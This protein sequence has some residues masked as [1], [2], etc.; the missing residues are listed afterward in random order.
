MQKRMSSIISLALM[1]FAYTTSVYAYVGPVISGQSS[2]C[3][4]KAIAG[5]VDEIEALISANDSIIFSYLEEIA[6]QVDVIES[7]IDLIGSDA[8]LLEIIDNKLDVV[9]SQDNA[10]SESLYEVQITDNTILSIVEEIDGKIDIVIANELAI[11]ASIYDVQIGVNDILASVYDVQVVADEILSKIC[12]ADSQLD[13]IESKIDLIV[14]DE[15][16]LE[17]IDSKLDVV[18]SQDDAIS[19]SIYDMQLDV[20]E[21]LSTVQNNASEIEEIDSQLDVIEQKIDNL[22]N[23]LIALSESNLEILVSQLDVIDSTVDV[24]NN[25]LLILNSITDDLMLLMSDLDAISSTIYAN[26]AGLDSL[27]EIVDNSIMEVDSKIDIVIDNELAILASIYDVQIGV[28][29]ILASVYD[30]QVVAD[31]ILSKVCVADSQLDVIESKLDL[32]V[33]DES[34]LE[35]IDSKLDVVISQDNAISESLYEVQITDNTILSLVEVIDGKIDTVIANELAI[36]ASIYDVQI[37]VNDILA[38]VYDM[39]VD[40]DIILSKVCVADSQLDVIESKLDLLVSDESLLEVINSKVDVVISQDNAISESLYEVQI[41]DNTILSIVEE[42]DG[43]IDIVIANELAILA[44]IY[45]VQI[46]V[47]D[48]LASVYDMQVDVDIILSKICVADS[49]LDVIESKLDLLVSDESLLEVINSKVDVIISQD[50]AIS[51]S[52]YD[53]Q[54]TDNTIL[55]VVEVVNSTVDAISESLY[56]VQIGVNDILA[57]VYDMQVDVDIILSKICVADSQLDVIESKLDLLVSDESLLEVINSKLDVVISQ[58][59]AISQ[60]LYDVQ[61]TDNTILSVVEVVNSTVDAISESLYDVQIGVNDILASVY[62]MQVDVDIILS[63]ICVADSQLDV[64]ESKLDLLVSDESLLEVINSKVD[65]VISQDNA[66]SESLYEVQITDN[67]ILS[68]V[69]EIDGKIDIVISNE[70]AILASIY[71]VQIGVNDILASV[72]DMQVDVDIILSK[73]CVADSQL[74][75]IESKLD[76]LVSDESLLEVINSKVDVVISQDNAISQSLYDVQITDNTILSVVEVVDSTVDAISESLYDVQI[77]V[78]DI[79]ASVYDMQVDVDIILSK[80]C[81][82]D[83]QLDVIESKIDLIG[84]DES[85]LEVINSKVDV[86]ISQDNAI[87]QSLYDVQITDNTILSVVEVVNSTVDAISESLYDVQIGVN[88]ILASVYDMQVD[89]DIILS[90]IC[91]ADSQLDVIESKLDLLVSDESLLEV[92]NSKVDVI[93]SQDNAISQS[94]YEVQITDN[95]ILSVVEVVNSTVDAIS[96]SLYDVQIGVNDI[97]ASVYDMQVDV[98][99]ILSKVCVAD[100]QLDVIE[101]KL[102]LLVSDESLLEVINSKVDVVISQ[103]NAISQSLYDVQITDNTILLVVEVVDS[104]V[105]AISESVYDLQL[106]ANLI[107]SNVQIIESIV[108]DMSFQ[109]NVIESLIEAGQAMCSPTAITA[110][111]TI[112]AAGNYCLA[113]SITGTIVVA[114]SDVYLDLNNR[115]VTGTIDILPSQNQVMIKNGVVDANG[116]ETGIWVEGNNADITIA[117]VMV[118]N[119]NSDMNSTGIVFYFAQDVTIENCTLTQNSIGLQLNN[120]YNVQVCDTVASSNMNVGFD[121]ISSFTN[122]FVNCKA[123]STGQ[124]NSVIYNN[125]VVGFSSEN[126]YGNIFER[127]IANGTQ[128]LSTTD[129]N[130]LV[131][132]FALHGTE[133]CTKIIGCESSNAMAST[134]GVTVPYGILLQGTLDG[135]L[136]ATGALDPN[137]PSNNDIVNSVNWSSDGQYLAVGGQLYSANNGSGYGLQIYSF[138]RVSNTLL[139]GPGVLNPVGGDVVNSVNWSPNGQYVAV[140]GQLYSANNGSGYSLQIYSFDRLNNTL[141]AGPGAFLPSDSDSVISVNWSPNGQYVAVGGNLSSVGYGLQIYSFD[142]VSNTLLAGP[143]TLN[144][145]DFVGAVNWSPDGQYV[146]VGGNFSSVGY[147]FQI[148]N[149]N[150]SNNTLL[151]GPGEL[152]P[153]ND[154]VSSVNWSPDGQYVAIGGNFP[155]VGYSFQIYSFNRSSNELLAGPGEFN[156]SDDSAASVNW[157][158]DGQYIVVGGSFTSIG[159]CFQIYSFNRSGN[160]LLPGP[161]EFNS[162][163]DGVS[164]VNW[165]PDGQYVAVGGAL[166][167]VNSPFGFGFEILTALQFPSQNVITDNTVYCNGHDVSATFTGAVGVGISG[168][169]ICNMITRNT[170]YNNPPT[171]SNFFV[172]SNYYFVTNVFNPLFGQAP[173]ALQN[174]SLNACDPIVAPIDVGLL[175]QQILYNVEDVIP[176]QLDMIE[177]AILSAIENIQTP[178]SPTAITAGTTITAAGNYCLSNSIADNIVVAASDVY[179]DLNNRTVTGTIDILPSQ[180]QVTI[181]NGVVDANG[182]ETGI[183]VEGNNAGITIANVTVKNANSDM[184][185]TGI[186]FYF[187]QDV[188]IENCTLTQNSIGLQLNNSYNV[189]VCDTVASSNV[190]AGFDLI[191][192]FTNSFINCKALS[193]GQGNTTIYNNEVAG[194]VSTNGYGNIFEQCIANATQALS[195]TDS[196]SLV[197]GFVLRGTEGCTKIIGCESANATASTSGVTVPYGILLQGTL[198]GTFN[199][200]GVLSHSTDNVSSVNWSPDSQYVA[201]GGFG[202]TDD[203]YQL[204]GYQLQ[205]YAFDRVNN[206]LTSV[207]GALNTVGEIVNSVNWSPD[208]Q[209][210]AIGGVNITDG[211]GTNNQFQIYAFDRVNN[212]LTPVA[213]ALPSSGGIVLGKNVQSVNWSPD[214]QFVATT[215]IQAVSIFPAMINGQ[216]QIFAFN[217]ITESLTSAA[218]VSL[219]FDSSVAALEVSWSPDGQY[220]A[221]GGAGI[222]GGYPGG[223]QFQIFE[224]DRSD[225]SLTPVAGRL[226]N[227]ND[228]VQSVNWSPDGQYVAIGGNTI[229]DGYPGGNQFQIFAFDRSTN[230]LMPVAGTLLSGDFVY[231][232]NWSPDG[233]YIAIGGTDLAENSGDQFQIFAFDESNNSLTP[234]AGSLS[235][236][237]DDLVNS[238]NW[239]TDGQYVVIGGSSITEN[240]GNQF[241]IFTGIQ[242]PSQNVITD[243]TVYC[244][245]HDVSATFTGAIGVGISGTSICNMITRNTAYNNPPTTSNFF[246]PSNYYFVTNVFNPLFGQAPTALQNISLNACDPIV[247][248]IDVGLLAQQILYNVEDVIPSQLNVIEATILTAIENIQTQTPCAPI[249]I[250]AGTTITAAGNY[251][252]ANSITDDIVVAASDVYLDLN[253]RTV[254]GTID[255]L[256]SQNQVTIKN[257]VVDANGGETGIWVEGNNSDITIANVTVKNANSDMNSTGIVFYFAQDVTI[258]NCTL[259]QNSIGLQLNNSYNVQV[260][261]TV[262]SS[263]M[264]VGFDLISSFTNS[265]INCKALSTGQNNAVIYNN[266]VVGFSSENGY[267]NIFERCIAN[268]TQALSTTDSNSTIAGFALRGTEGCTKIIGCESSN[269]TASSSGVTVPYGILLQGTLDGTFNVTGALSHSTDNVSSVN[270]SP[271]SQYVAVGGFGITDDGYQL[272]GYQLQIYAFDRVNNNLTAVGGALNAVADIVNSVNWSPDGQYIAIGGVNITDGYGTNNQFQ[273]YAFD[274]VNNSLTPVAGALP[275]SG[276]I[277]LGKNV[278]SVNWSPDGQFVATT[279]IQA[280]SI[281]P[282]MINGQVQIFA[283]NKI[284]ESLT[285]AAVVSLIFDSSVAALEVSWSPDGQYVAVGG[286]GITGGYPGGNQFQIFEFDRSDNSLTPV[287]GRLSNS[288]DVVKSVNWSPDGQ[289]VAIGGV[290]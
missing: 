169:S 269:A 77:G 106:T 263:N 158:S 282:A 89:V 285:S 181:K 125:E 260:C 9:I 279:I 152:N 281:F 214:G 113:N 65:V 111:T 289:Y 39:Q 86:I 207:G 16:L 73:I 53:V 63:K 237:A 75:V 159:N 49:Q 183:W 71:D 126:G 144:S 251:C 202:I 179:L 206:N 127:C 210:I 116:G 133:G 109:L 131:A 193:T 96:E 84:S 266:E 209:Y 31:E 224:F 222:T 234:V 60:S 236:I 226:S 276:G 168:T 230:H 97:L 119:A 167:S 80:V 19:E 100:S 44:S 154:G 128:A 117:N 51:Q 108:E 164:S 76:L 288:N 278:Q 160:E 252:L 121:L 208:G 93:I 255:I 139:A 274:R 4:S 216:V 46:G 290:L 136:G 188:T 261:D 190:N 275:S 265:F 132:G 264:N 40:V 66:I 88:D 165:S 72:Y 1:C 82:A 233:R 243:N 114:A 163:D 33:S 184:N 212:S 173:T 262:A 270:W 55:S 155:S 52:L 78:N 62:D 245:G 130:S 21:I 218:V 2:W 185:S 161:G 177:A 157:S 257:G 56:D 195:T 67:T 148:Y 189:N 147:S 138:D 277:V 47:N 34:L 107:E 43:K 229:T 238:V 231:S 146:A 196:S 50:N 85:L 244:N 95:T 225:N 20:D 45:D 250:T 54:I 197:A 115:T 90:K 27:L 142:R 112:A 149:F 162:S 79:L 7:L 242:F 180:N 221:V 74:D 41:T 286:A 18:I 25:K 240:S 42:I 194:F 203:G 68:I 105:D 29:D 36:L 120:S 273:I 99:I 192:S 81:V 140:G 101:S 35:V 87:S 103:D 182:G 91:V 23:I 104:T 124:N 176:S 187:A 137:Y 241:Q 235:D 284:T 211:Y 64:I 217:K 205:I 166:R 272:A 248:P 258:E 283:F 246:V 61:I 8:S 141:L 59:N 268:G 38:S 174:I 170:A 220:V 26:L 28:N 129:S 228:V 280:V 259:T 213:G 134:S 178:C 92:I 3:I 200:T 102:D 30:V 94:L 58:D 69:E 13:V 5:T 10:I 150:R 239:S 32:L 227:S 153:S 122:S 37:G 48:I 22:T 204:A 267:G 6:S 118:K 215:I 171:T 175:A 199:V 249:A 156:P 247:A 254:T 98:D 172:P 271:D 201:V 12:V 223:N 83:S 110:G 151:A 191:S 232:V 198:D 11:L 186:V 287:A 123:L 24:I 145:S 70:L 253:N 143:G 219:I 14:S 17:I 15:S 135:L 256:P 57:S